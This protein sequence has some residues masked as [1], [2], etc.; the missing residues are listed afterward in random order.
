MKNRN[1]VVDDAD[2]SILFKVGFIRWFDVPF[3]LGMLVNPVVLSAM[4]IKG[5]S[6][7]THA[8]LAVVLAY[9]MWVAILVFRLMYFTINNIT[10]IKNVGTDAARMA[11]AYLSGKQV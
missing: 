9:L 11:A 3:I 4:Y 5:H 1:E 6:G 2:L 8:L 10:A 7:L